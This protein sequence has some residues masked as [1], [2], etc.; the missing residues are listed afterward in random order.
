MLGYMQPVQIRAFQQTVW[1]Y[2]R[3]SGRH[4]L[5]WRMTE[6]DGSYDPYRIV[7]SEIMLQQTQV[8]TVIP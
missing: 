8:E 6:A 7:I 5:P 3:Q 1:G 2:Y 4:D